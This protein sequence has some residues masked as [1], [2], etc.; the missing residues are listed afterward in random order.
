MNIDFV[1]QAICRR[2]IAAL[3]LLSILSAPAVVRAQAQYNQDKPDPKFS[4]WSKITTDSDEK[5][6]IQNMLRGAS[7]L[8]TAQFSAFF[9]GVVFPHFTLAE[10]IY[11]SKS[12]KGSPNFKQTE[13]L[14]PKLRKDFKSAF[15][16]KDTTS[17]QARDY[18]NQITLSRMTTIAAGNYHP[19]A[20][21]N[22]MLLIAELNSDEVN[23]V[24]Y[25]EALRIMV[26]AASSSNTLEVVRVA[27]LIGIVRHAKAGINP[28][29]QRP[30]AMYLTKIITNGQP[31]A[32]SSRAGHDWIRRRALEALTAM[33]AKNPPQD[34]TFLELL[35]TVLQD[36]DSTMEL[37][38]DAI[39]SLLSVKAVA[40][41]KFDADKMAA[42][43]G[44]VA[45]D[46]YRRELYASNQHGRPISSDGMKFYFTLVEKG[47]TALEGVAKSPTIDELKTSLGELVETAVLEEEDK[48]K[49]LELAFYDTVA[50][51]GAK[52][53]SVVTGKPVTEI[54]PKRDPVGG[55]A[56]AAGGYTGG[57]VG[58]GTTGR[59]GVGYGAAPGYGRGGAGAG[60]NYGRPQGGSF[61]GRR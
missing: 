31:R 29:W 12:A 26:S 23:E 5:R 8:D 13:S 37:R 56:P 2:A 55:N 45:V 17:P 47:L 25:P 39:E 14:L 9:N 53:E 41:Q 16:G 60:S 11:S 43:I 35:N 49:R 58:Y 33:Y 18:L 21:Y 34:G 42:G 4:T 54:R 30:L 6:A 61:G 15:L 20:R 19:H 50:D 36:K 44:Q 24:P 3:C 52:Y 22:A 51:A 28:D 1:A 32:D 7:S 38:A 57:G 27:A 59:G 46:A 48:A 40:P 10:N